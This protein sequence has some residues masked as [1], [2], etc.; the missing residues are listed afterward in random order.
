MAETSEILRT[1]DSR[2]ENLPG[3]DFEPHY[4]DLDGVRMHYLDEGRGNPILLLHGQPSWS[5]LYRKMI[6]ALSRGDMRAIAPDMIGFGRSDK[7]AN[8]DYYSYARHVEQMCAFVESLDLQNTT[9]FIQDWG[10]LVGLRVVAAMPDRFARIV[11]ANTGFPFAEPEKAAKQ[12]RLL[13]KQVERLG[14]VRMRDMLRAKKHDH[15]LWSAYAKTAKDFGAGRV[16]RSASV[17]KLP[18]DVVAAYDAPFP[19]E[20]HKVCIR[21]MPMLVLEELEN[22]HKVW[23]DVFLKW[24]KPFLTAF[25]DKDRVFSGTENLF[26]DAIPGAKGQKHVIVRDAGHF[27]QEEKGEELAGIVAY[28][29]LANS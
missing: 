22:N 15:A 27:L 4:A 23:T 24:E 11:A 6:P 10:G 20:P 29:V 18:D 9:L 25:S 5:Y 3:Y 13:E 17:A 1:P 2:F 21:R 8:P 28:F 16:V 14:E 26:Q 12:R 7:P 19:D